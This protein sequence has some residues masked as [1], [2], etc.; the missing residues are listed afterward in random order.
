MA[1]R[2]G[3]DPALNKRSIDSVSRFCIK[4]V[5][6]HTLL[7]IFSETSRVQEDPVGADLPH[8][9]HDAAQLRP[10]V[11]HLAH[12][13]LRVRGAALGHRTSGCQVKSSLVSFLGP[14]L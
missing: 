5:A 7:E 1:L 3:R 9:E 11:G 8:L 6:T 4:N 14:M 12:L 2:P 13:L 10:L